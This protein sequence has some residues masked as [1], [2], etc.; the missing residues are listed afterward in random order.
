MRAA[1]P[2]R[3]RSLYEAC[4]AIVGDGT[5]EDP[6]REIRSKLTAYGEVLAARHG[7]PEKSWSVYAEWH[8]V[9]ARF[10]LRDASGR[11]V[12]LSKLPEDPEEL[13]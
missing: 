3:K 8:S 4:A 11:E 12:D 2:G 7:D 9:G 10:M 1:D 6:L 13:E 5:A